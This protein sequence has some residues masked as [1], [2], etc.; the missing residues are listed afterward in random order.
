MIINIKLFITTAQAKFVFISGRELYDAYLADLSDRDFAISSIFTGV[1]NVDSFLTPEGGQTDV[2][3]M[4]EWYIA[5]RLLPDD[6]L[7][8][9]EKENATDNWTLKKEMPS[10]KWY[11]EY[12]ITECKNDARDAAYIIGFLHIF[13]AYLTHISNG[14]PKKIF[15]Y[16]DKFV[17]RN[18]D[19][20]SSTNWNDVCEV[21]LPNTFEKRKHRHKD[22]AQVLWFD[23]TG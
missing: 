22:T 20:V 19:S 6:W 23:Q 11:Y 15:L 14:S 9:K 3:S 5:N 16:F 7:R 13:A 21:G 12:L 8:T 17:K 18:I 1:I 2:R 4:S 10:L